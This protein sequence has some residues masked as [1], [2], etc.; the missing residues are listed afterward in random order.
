M[1]HSGLSPDPNSLQAE[2]AVVRQCRQPFAGI[3]Y[4]LPVGVVEF[5]AQTIPRQRYGAEAQLAYAVSA[6]TA[7]S[8]FPALSP[9]PRHEIIDPVGGEMLK[10]V[11]MP[12]DVRLHVMRLQNR[13]Q[14]ALEFK[15]I[16]VILAGGIDWMVTK[17]E[18]PTRLWTRR[19]CAAAS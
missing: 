3:I 17:D 19:A 1:L 5:D 18:F 15:C 14:A 12:A 2:G 4:Q 10:V 9:C 11:L 7:P 16:A 6:S 13:K 8:A